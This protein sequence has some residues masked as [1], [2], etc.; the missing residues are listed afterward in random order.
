MLTAEVVEWED[1]DE[2]LGEEISKE[3][4]LA[5]RRRLRR[6]RVMGSVGASI[7]GLVA[8]LLVF[9]ILVDTGIIDTDNFDPTPLESTDLVSPAVPDF[10]P[11][12]GVEGP[13]TSPG[14]RPTV[15]YTISWTT[16]NVFVGRGGAMRVNITNDAPTQMY[17]DRV[18]M[19]PEWGDGFDVFA[20]SFGTYIDPGEEEFIGLLGFSG[21]SAPGIYTYHFELD[22][23]QR[24][25]ALGWADLPGERSSDSEVE[26]LPAGPVS[27]YPIHVND[28]D[29]YREVNDLVEPDDPDVVAVADQV[30]AGLGASY[31]LYWVASLFEWGLLELEYQSDP[32]EE[33]VWSPAGKTCSLKSGDCEDFSIVIASVVEH[34]GG[35]ARFYIISKHAFAAVYVG[36]PEMDTQAA[37]TALNRFYGTALRYSWF[38]D[39]LGYWIIAD[40]TSSQF[41]GGLPYNGVAT[42]AQGGWDIQ[43]TEYLYVTDIYPGYPE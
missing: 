10:D 38:K 11:G 41:L 3:E 35:N 12:F 24:R 29:V 27:G 37:A 32:S 42:D 26:V 28:K 15:R 7:A 43:D 22:I 20:T 14:I 21:P 9:A 23:R 4:F 36:G 40:G 25:P 39:D 6:R 13:T 16:T 5:E 33:D 8:A 17:V 2:E 19:V 30:S 1:D 31:N 34:W 18:R